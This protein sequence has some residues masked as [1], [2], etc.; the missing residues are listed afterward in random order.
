MTYH[1]MTHHVAKDALTW[2]LRMREKD[3]P[4]PSTVPVAQAESQMYWAEAVS[5]F[6]T[7]PVTNLAKC[8][9]ESK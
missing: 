8:F 3:A 1:K 7:I 9:C 5:S 6:Y 2:E 4:Q